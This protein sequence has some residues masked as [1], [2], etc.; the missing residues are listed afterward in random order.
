MD[1][2]LEEERFLAQLD[3]ELAGG[4]ALCVSVGTANDHLYCTY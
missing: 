3:M 2:D 1:L 4:E